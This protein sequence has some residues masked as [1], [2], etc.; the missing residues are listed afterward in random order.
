MKNDPAFRKNRPVPYLAGPTYQLMPSTTGPPVNNMAPRNL[1]L[2][3][4]M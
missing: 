3:S 1:S 4:G 2:L